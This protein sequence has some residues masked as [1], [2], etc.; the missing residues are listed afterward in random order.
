MVLTTQ[1]LSSLNPGRTAMGNPEIKRIHHLGMTVSDIPSAVNL[2]CGILGLKKIGS[3]ELDW[4]YLKFP[5][6][7]HDTQLTT[8][9]T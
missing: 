6:E 7:I 1:F 5:G 9:F 4:E 2:L 3:K 8:T